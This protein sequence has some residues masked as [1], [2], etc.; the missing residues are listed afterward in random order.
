MTIQVGLRAQDIGEHSFAHLFAVTKNYGLNNV[1]LD[2]RKF[3]PKI[4]PNTDAYS[5]GL[6][7]M[8]AD[9]FREAGVRI[10]VLGNYV[11]IIDYDRETQ[12]E[13]LQTFA[14]SLAAASFLH[15]GVVGTETGS[16]LSPAGFSR[17]NYTVEALTRVI[18]A[19][20]V[21][22]KDA[23]RLGSPLAIE[24]GVNHPMNNNYAVRQVIDEVNSPNLFVIFDLA[25]MLT[26]DN[27]HDQDDILENANRLYGNR[28]WVFHLSD[29]KFVDG[30]R[31]RVPFGS[32]VVDVERYVNF[33]NR[34]KPFAYAILEG[35]G[36]DE[37]DDVVH[38][39]HK[40]DQG[41]ALK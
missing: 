39:V 6:L 41:Y 11:N 27:F 31:V 23:D 37:L 4:I 36:E 7:N 5:P 22:A 13:N 9:K 32:G 2:P 30:Q 25:N 17:D 38:L 1:Q 10:A 19:V 40:Y 16:V 28:I 12:W 8:V 26:A 18:A 24:P 29:I 33:I 21:M 35:T 34:V 14:D 3:L 15:A 20:K